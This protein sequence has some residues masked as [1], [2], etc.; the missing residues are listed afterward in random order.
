[1]GCVPR[2]NKDIFINGSIHVSCGIL[3]LVVCS[4]VEAELAALFLMMREAK[5]LQL[6]LEEMSNQQHYYIV[7]RVLLLV[8]QMELSRSRDHILWRCNLL[9]YRPS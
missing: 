3:Q 2:K 7:I 5:I 8:L 9:D 4:V 6:M 1:M